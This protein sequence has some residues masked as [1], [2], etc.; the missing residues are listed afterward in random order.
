MDESKN[1]VRHTRQTLPA[2][3]EIKS[4][5]MLSVP[6]ANRGELAEYLD[7]LR[8]WL[9]LII[10]ATLAVTFSVMLL[11]SLVLTKYYQAKAIIRPVPKSDQT[12]ALSGYAS[13]LTTG[14]ASLAG[15]ETDEEK[16]AEEYMTILQSYAFTAGLL[17][18]TNLGPRLERRSLTHRLFGWPVTSYR[19]YKKMDRLFDCDYSVK[20]GNLTL[21]FMDPDPAVAERVL[22]SYITLLG[23][24]LKEREVAS[25]IAAR[26]VLEK[27]VASISDN[28][29]QAAIYD[30]V[31]KQIE[32]KG[33]AEVQ[34]DFSF[35]VVDPPFVPDVPHSPSPPLDTI[36]ALILT[37]TI[38]VLAIIMIERVIEALGYHKSESSPENS[39]NLGVLDEDEPPTYGSRPQAD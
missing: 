5:V 34:A 35:R 4:M 18:R 20:T 24:K 12:G 25:A 19:L 1:S 22:G 7:L 33:L 23:E 30:I 28:Q 11:T 37:P 13:S 14:I 3:A 39:S 29:L 16:D 27:E 38:L 6:K 17:G 36:L 32:R 2:Q 15:L 26:R 10:R 9:R 31:A 21:T 8:P